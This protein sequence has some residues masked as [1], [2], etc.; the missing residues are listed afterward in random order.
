ME[1]LFQ[2][3]NTL[4]K[5]DIQRFLKYFWK[6]ISKSYF[7]LPIWKKLLIVT[8]GI[9]LLINDTVRFIFPIFAITMTVVLLMGYARIPTKLLSLYFSCSSK[10]YRNLIKD[11]PFT[12]TFKFYEEYIICDSSRITSSLKNFQIAYTSLIGFQEFGDFFMIFANNSN[13][14][15]FAFFFS[16]EDHITLK[17]FLSNHHCYILDKNKLYSL[18][19]LK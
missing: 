14:N 1:P 17:N 18:L 15:V 4:V 16:K 8:F 7:Y 12:L 6:Y 10:D 13:D 19:N 9:F 3:E 5:T 2:V 11:C